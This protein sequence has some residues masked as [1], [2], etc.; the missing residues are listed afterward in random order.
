MHS[1]VELG[2]RF[3]G[4]QYLSGWIG[5]GHGVSVSDPL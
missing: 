5:S 2:L 1:S 3:S 4:Q